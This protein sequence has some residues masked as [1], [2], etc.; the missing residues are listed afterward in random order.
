MQ[1][2]ATTAT[3]ANTGINNLRTRVDTVEGRINGLENQGVDTATINGLIDDKIG[4]FPTKNE[5]TT[6]INTASEALM[7]YAD[8]TGMTETERQELTRLSSAVDTKLSISDAENTY[9]TKTQLNNAICLSFP[10]AAIENLFFRNNI[11]N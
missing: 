9:A 4:N 7:D 8:S 11:S 1:P 5:V 10:K 3:S 2:A 6:Q